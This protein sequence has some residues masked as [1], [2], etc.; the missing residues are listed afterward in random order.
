MEV[1]VNTDLGGTVAKHVEMA[2]KR[3]HELAAIQLC[4]KVAQSALGKTK[5]LGFVRMKR[6]R[7][8]V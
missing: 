8:Q 6:V 4:P 3:A 7:N 5:K 1:G 2:N